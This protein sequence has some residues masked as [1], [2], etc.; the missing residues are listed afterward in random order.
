MV[1]VRAIEPLANAMQ[2]FVEHPRL[3]LRMGVRSRQLAVERFD[4]KLVNETM[5]REMRL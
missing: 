4:V 5:I 3:V 1:P 2:K